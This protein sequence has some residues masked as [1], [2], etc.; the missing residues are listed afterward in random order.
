MAAA[1]V[2]AAALVIAPAGAP[3]QGTKASQRTASPEWRAEVKRVPQP[4]PV[5]MND[6]TE[7]VEFA[8]APFPYEGVVPATNKP[9]LD[10]T[11]GERRGHRGM[12]GQIYWADETYSDRRVLLHLPKGFDPRKPSLMIVF[13]H[14]HGATLERDVIE[15]QQV[16]AQITRSGINAVLVAPQFAYDAADSSAGKFWQQGSMLWFLEEAAQK[17]AVL[18]GDPQSVRA[19]SRMPIMFIAYSGGYVPAAWAMHGGGI[20]KRVRAVLLLDA[21]YGEMD[22]FVAWLARD[23]STIFVSAYTHLTAENNSKLRRILTEREIPFATELA[24]P[25]PAGSVTFVATEEE[26]KHRDYVTQ[27]WTEQPIRDLLR[28]FKD[29]ALRR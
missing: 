8:M 25:L 26:V 22:K 29:Y 15:R 20:A 2:Y 27:A 6:I 5:V 16:A 3:A 9:F 24:K 23:R 18:H 1:G 12:R 11:E 4:R 10:V 28:G 21:L 14:G 7:L 17:L 13:F 19:F